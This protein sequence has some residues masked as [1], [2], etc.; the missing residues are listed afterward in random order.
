MKTIIYPKWIGAVPLN[1]KQLK[2]M[3]REDLKNSG[4]GPKKVTLIF[5]VCFVVLNVLRF[6]LTEL[7]GKMDMGGNYLS[8]AI[9]AEAKTMAL[10]YVV[11]FAMQLVI[12]L[13]CVGYTAAALE[14]KNRNPVG[15]GSLLAGFRLAGR[16]IMTYVLLDL[17]LGLLA[18]VCSLPLSYILSMVLMVDETVISEDLMMAIMVIYVGVVMFLLS[19][20]YRTAFF[21]LMD[22]PG[23]NARQ[24]LKQAS[25]ITRG[26]RVQ[27]F[28]L[29]LSF[30][31]WILLSVLTC[32]VLFV[33]KLP[34]IMT[35]YAHA[36]DYLL[37]DYKQ[38][39]AHFQQLREKM[40]RERMQ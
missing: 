15:H 8:N 31:P 4:N 16:A 20:R 27:L 18:S 19:Y 17:L 7:V 33:W 14:M 13:L 21:G 1:R 22:N 35:T 2:A 3:A 30:L 9:S 12:M 40:M 23:L 25:N 28:L 37:R 24:A 32:G 10:T 34:Y 5:L 26:H 38:R 6:V 29:D 11:S 36:Y 39:Q